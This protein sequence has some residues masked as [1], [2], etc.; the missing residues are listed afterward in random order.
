VL[1]GVF[2]DDIAAR[3]G[4]CEATI[5]QDVKAIYATWAAEDSITTK[6]RIA[7]RVR[8]L[9]LAAR[10]AL[11]GFHRSKNNVESL[12]TTY[13]RRECSA[14]AGKKAVRGVA[15]RTCDGTGIELVENITRKV[16]GQAGDAALLKVY[17][18]SVK[19]AARLQGL[20]AFVKA[21]YNRKKLPEQQPVVNLYANV[22]WDKVPSD[23]IL[24][25]K[26]ACA[27]ALGAAKA[28]EVQS[29]PVDE[30]NE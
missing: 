11:E 21:K 4:V 12:Q 8:Q 9:E 19:E 15:C 18:D 26:Y 28:L 27:Q 30:E 2:Q 14:C 29:A 25:I 5:T 1:Q 13:D 24:Q 23:Q 20:Y 10:E 17:L 7:R 3:M 6:E 16:T 22:N